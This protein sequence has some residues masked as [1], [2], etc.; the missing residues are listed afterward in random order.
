MS[1][2]EKEPRI[3]MMM[4][5]AQKTIGDVIVMAGYKEKM[6]VISEPVYVGAVMTNKGMKEMWHYQVAYYAPVKRHWTVRFAK[7]ISKLWKR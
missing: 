4:M 5:P 6:I 7:W 2:K 1:K 3:D